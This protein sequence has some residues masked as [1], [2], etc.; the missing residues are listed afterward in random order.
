M[1]GFSLQGP[2]DRIENCII[3][4]LATLSFSVS[5]SILTGLVNPILP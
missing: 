5:L 4:Q 2:A 3:K 1:N